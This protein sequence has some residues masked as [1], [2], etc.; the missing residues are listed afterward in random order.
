MPDCSWKLK[1]KIFT[2]V[3]QCDENRSLSGFRIKTVSKLTEGSI[4]HV[5]SGVRRTLMLKLVGF[6]FCNP[7][8]L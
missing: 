7:E 4:F 8:R 2:S 5:K 6:V 1:N 3:A